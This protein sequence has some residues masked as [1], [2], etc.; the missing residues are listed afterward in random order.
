M[1]T[2]EDIIYEENAGPS[3][4][5]RVLGVLCYM[6]FGFAIPF[7]MKKRSDFISFH[8]KRG[9]VIFG[10]YCI[11]VLLSFFWFLGTLTLIYL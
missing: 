5:D 6:P 11:A 1:I 3:K 7:L 2:P 9:G 4:E 8:T 10:L